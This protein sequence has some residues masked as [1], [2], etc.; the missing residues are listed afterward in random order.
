MS[1]NSKVSGIVRIDPKT[2]PATKAERKENRER[3][4]RFFLT[5][6]TQIRNL[7]YGSPGALH[8]ATKLNESLKKLF[9][10]PHLWLIL[11]NEGDKLDPKF[12]KDID[13]D[14][15]VEQAPHPDN[16]INFH[17]IIQ[18]KHLYIDKGIMLNLEA[19]RM[20]MMAMTGVRAYVS[21]RNFTN[22]W[23]LQNMIAYIEK[24]S[25]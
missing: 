17:A 7:P 15:T 16:R 5:G 1:F 25:T 22:D 24:G 6:N 3:Q 11:N 14:F 8:L 19:F 9:A 13:V 4:G 20:L 21:V 12:L 2:A 18:L 23:A 10:K